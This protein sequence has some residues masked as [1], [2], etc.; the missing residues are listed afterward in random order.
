MQ[1]N[2]SGGFILN[3]LSK[4]ITNNILSLFT[5]FIGIINFVLSKHFFT[6]EKI[7]GIT[8][9][10]LLGGFRDINYFS[11]SY[12]II[13]ILPIFFLVTQIVIAMSQY[14]SNIFIY[15]TLRTN[16]CKRLIIF[17]YKNI[18]IKTLINCFIYVIVQ[19][20]LCS[21]EYS[22]VKFSLTIEYLILYAIYF[23]IIFTLTIAVILYLKTYLT[24]LVMQIIVLLDLFIFYVLIALEQYRYLGFTLLST[25]YK[26]YSP[27]FE[28]FYLGII[29]KTIILIYILLFI[30][31]NKIKKMH[32]GGLNEF[33]RSE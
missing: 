14:F 9:H 23:T 5:I 31:N 32:K 3:K 30:I 4:F 15:I 1:N 29:L 13:K 8:L 33:F 6:S 2:Y 11:S 7:T 24:M 16:S 10:D 22:T 28:N 20:I 26:N 27:I 19:S 18:Y 12:V 21:I 25:I 17:I